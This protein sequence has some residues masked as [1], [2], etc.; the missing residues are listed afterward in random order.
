MRVMLSC[1][2]SL[3]LFGG[4][5]A[6]V[7]GSGAVPVDVALTT[8]AGEIYSAPV[9]ITVA[10][11]AYSRAAAWIVGGA[12]LLLLALIAVNLVRRIRVRRSGSSADTS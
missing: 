7:L 11:S 12:F 1:P 8:P 2:Y 3:S 10:T 9:T 4:V 6:Q 5:Q